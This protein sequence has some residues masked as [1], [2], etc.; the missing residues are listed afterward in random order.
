MTHNH[1]TVT[2]IDPP[3]DPGST[4][5][6]IQ[7]ALDALPESGG[8]LCLKSGRYLVRRS[9]HLRANVTIRG[10]GAATI[11]MRPTPIFFTLTA[12]APALPV[13]AELSAVDGLQPGDE[14]YIRDKG[15]GGWHARHIIIEHI[16]NKL[17][18]GSIVAGDPRRS[19][20]PDADGHGGNF[21]PMIMIPGS[22]NAMVADL[23]IDGGPHVYSREQMPGFTCSGVHGV[24]AENLRVRDI[25]VRRWP[26]DGI[27]AQGGSAFVTEC[28]VED[29]LGHGFHPGSNITHSIWNNN[30]AR[31][32]GQDG[33]YFCRGVR[34]AIVSGNLLIENRMNGIGNLSAP[35]AYNVVTGNVI[36]RNGRHG[37]EAFEALGNVI[38]NNQVRDNSQSDVGRFAGIRLESHADNIVTGNLCLD[39]QTSPTQK[40]GIE[41]VDPAG[42]NKFADNH[43]TMVTADAVCQP[44]LGEIRT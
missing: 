42:E 36:A 15:Q 14:I 33:F 44:P 4:T 40:T 39:T 28:L 1:L 31:R 20:S 30:I 43:G 27:S 22:H 17:V 35:D 8:M 5:A 7:E 6:G 34:N 3:I 18:Q 9:I 26:S 13:E 2:N 25:T 23:A 12:V 32:N 19:Y 11:L 29:C 21:F 24:K 37:I 41:L 38:G 16:H 10:E